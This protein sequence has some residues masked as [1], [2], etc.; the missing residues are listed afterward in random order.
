MFESLAMLIHLG[1]KYGVAKGLWPAPGS[2]QSAEALSWTVWSTVTLGTHGMQVM[3]NTSERVP[4][5]LRNEGQ[6]AQGKAELT[7]DLAILEAKLEGRDY[8]LGDTFTLTDIAVASAA[9]FFAR[10]AGSERD[11][12]PR[13]SAW[14]ARCLGRPAM[15]ALYA[16]T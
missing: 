4:A 12:F 11:A 16:A 15:K 13:V 7:N 8:L 14:T 1:E 6:A 5:E 10:I 3:T 2:A 9:S